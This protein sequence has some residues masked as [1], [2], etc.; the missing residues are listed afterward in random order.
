[1]RDSERANKHDCP[2]PLFSAEW[3]FSPSVDY[4]VLATEGRV[5]A[6]PNSLCFHRVNSGDRGRRI[7]LV[8]RL[9]YTGKWGRREMRKIQREMGERERLGERV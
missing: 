5:V 2:C 8:A 9:S 6:K 1:M 4:T 3:L 7:E